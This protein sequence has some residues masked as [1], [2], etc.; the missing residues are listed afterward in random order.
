VNGIR[1]QKRYAYAQYYAWIRNSG[2]GYSP[3]ATPVWLLAEERSCRATA[4]TGNACTGGAADEVVVGYDY[5]PA[6]G[7]I[8]NNL[9]LR[10]T[11]TTA[12]D[13]DGVVR[14]FRSCFGYDQEGNQIWTTSPR[15]GLG[16]CQ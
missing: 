1:S 2:G 14:S 11:F 15:A 8:G 5:G 3:A 7:A 10:G 12:Q 16:S 6:T 13:A 9:L 4:T